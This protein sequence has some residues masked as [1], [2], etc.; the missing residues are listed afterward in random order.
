MTVITIA[1]TNQELPPESVL[2][3]VRG[4]LFGVFDGARQA[5]QKAWRRFWRHM[6][7]LGPGEMA[8]ADMKFPRNPKFHRKFFALLQVGFDAWEPSR[9]RKSYKG[10]P[11]EKNFEQF[12]ED[13]TILSG[14]YVQTFDLKGH[15]VLR[16]KSISFANMDDAEFE[17]VYSAVADVLLRDVLKSYAGRAELDAVVDQMMGF[18]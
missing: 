9:K 12:R 18:L 3:Q 16:A 14:H 5:D 7:N 11:V 13:V 10:R 8:Q 17:Q 4:F 6:V 15:M 1:R 2:E